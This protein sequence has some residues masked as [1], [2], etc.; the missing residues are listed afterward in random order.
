ME[1]A[2]ARSQFEICAPP[3]VRLSPALPG[4][5]HH[6]WSGAGGA[7]CQRREDRRRPAPGGL[8]ERASAP[9]SAFKRFVDH[10]QGTCSSPRAAA[11]HRQIYR[12]PLREGRKDILNAS[13]ARASRTSSLPSWCFPARRRRLCVVED[14][15][16]SGSRRSLLAWTLRRRMNSR[17]I[18]AIPCTLFVYS[19]HFSWMVL[20]TTQKT[21]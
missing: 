18:K 10:N 21:C 6:A 11:R 17:I 4:R 19:C 20:C 15:R 1:R 7:D 3:N 2:S 12:Y 14:E 16:E 8:R 9:T 5:K 13:F